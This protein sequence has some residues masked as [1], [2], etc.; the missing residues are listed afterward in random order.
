LLG[1]VLEPSF[2]SYSPVWR[3]WPGTNDYDLLSLLSGD[4]RSLGA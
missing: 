2:I 1:T 4:V 3:I